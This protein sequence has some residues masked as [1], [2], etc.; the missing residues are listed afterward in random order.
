[1]RALTGLDLATFC[2]LVE[3]FAAGCQAEAEARFSVERPRQR[4]VGGGRKGLLAGSEQKL[5]FLLVYLKT[6]P[7]FAVLGATFGLSLRKGESNWRYNATADN[8]SI[9]ASCR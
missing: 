1:M 9:T 7:T 5:L 2:A 8:I 6:Y 3:P 4:R